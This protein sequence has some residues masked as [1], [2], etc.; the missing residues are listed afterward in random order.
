MKR[1]LMPLVGALLTAILAA[2]ASAGTRTFHWPTPALSIA[3]PAAETDTLVAPGAVTVGGKYTFGRL[4]ISH[5][6]ITVSLYEGTACGVPPETEFFTLDPTSKSDLTDSSGAWSVSFTG[7]AAGDYSF[8]AQVTQHGWHGATSDCVPVT[9]GEVPAVVEPPTLAS[10]YLC[11]NRQMTDPIAYLDSVADQMWAT[12]GYFEPQAILG[13]VV[14]GTN[15]GAYHLVC[16]APSTMVQTAE[17]LSGSG[18]VYTAEQLKAYHQ[19]HPTGNDLNVY[20]IYK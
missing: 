8:Q 11:W 2:G 18:E 1:L 14:G 7:L 10:S 9:V 5:N 20:H 19:D 3:A 16:N 17:G 4:G 6:E 13:N 15:V 12:G